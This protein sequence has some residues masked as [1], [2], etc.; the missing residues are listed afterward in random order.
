M[1][2][3]LLPLRRREGA[4][5]EKGGFRRRTAEAGRTNEALAGP[6]DGPCAVETR[7]VGMLLRTADAPQ[8]GAGGCSRLA[9]VAVHNLGQCV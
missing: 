8:C 3:G 6:H 4:Q 5:T 2:N 7:F 1:D 9:V